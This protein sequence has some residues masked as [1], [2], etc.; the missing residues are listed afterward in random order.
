MRLPLQT[1]RPIASRRSC[2]RRAFTLIE[3]LVVIAIIAL[4]VSILLPSLAGAREAAKTTVCGSN[5]RQLSIS[6]LSYSNDQK[7]YF[8]SGNFDNRKKSG[9]GA[10]DTVGWIA[11]QVIGGYG[12]PG[13]LLCP[14]SPCRANQNLAL[15]RA[16]GSGTYTLST[17]ANISG[18]SEKLQTLISRGYN[19]NY[20]QSWFMA[21]TEMISVYPE[22]APDPKNIN[23]LKGPLR[24]SSLSHAAPPEKVPLFG[25]AASLI[26]IETN[27]SGDLTDRSP[28]IVLMPDG[29]QAFGCK[30]LTNGP[31]TG[32]MD[33]FGATQVWTRQDYSDF[34]PTHGKGGLNLFGNTKV[35]GNIGFADGHV[36]LF[37]DSNH[38]GQFAQH[39][40]VIQGIN[41]W[42]YDELEPKVY[43]GW[44]NRNGLPF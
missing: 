29:S 30:A 44:L 10:I 14:S 7:G 20:C 5:V 9:Y 24:D 36:D 12:N 35:F 42:V 25:D 40:G 37:K 31:L 34:G 17:V 43:G 27:S 32:V 15:S 26:S 19:S 4:L 33:G 39:Q 28:D 6:A 8:C 3:L 41:T 1:Q 18:A 21:N 38:D 23:F 2:S 22:R 16:T 13:K 11:D